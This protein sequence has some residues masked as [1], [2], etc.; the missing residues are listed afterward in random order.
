MRCEDAG[1][2]AVPKPFTL[3]FCAA[4]RLPEYLETVVGRF[5]GFRSWAFRAV[6][7]KI[8]NL[9]A[10]SQGIILFSVNQSQTNIPQN[11][12]YLS[13]KTDEQ[14]HKPLSE[15]PDNFCE[16]GEQTDALQASRILQEIVKNIHAQLAQQLRAL[17][18]C[19]AVYAEF[20]G[21]GKGCGIRDRNS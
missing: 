11:L 18:G 10:L 17:C 12:P 1:V 5:R 6:G 20:T 16:V 8:P 7:G 4:L 2:R 3:F 13:L 15:I 21:S 14:S 19:D 9:S